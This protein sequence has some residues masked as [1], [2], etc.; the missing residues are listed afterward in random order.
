MF[1][2]LD[3]AA[4][5]PVT[6]VC[7]PP[8]AG[9]TTLVA[10]YLDARKLRTLWYRMDDGDADLASFFYYLSLAAPKQKGSLPLYT[11]EYRQ[12]FR[13]FAGN[14]F[15]SLYSR[16]KSPFV[17]VF[18]DY[19]APAVNSPLNEVMR[20]ALA[21]LP[22]GGK[23]TFISRAEP[24]AFA[25]LKAK[26]MIEVLDWPWLRFTRSEVS[27]LVKRF[28]S[29]KWSNSAIDQL[30]ETSDGWAAG[31]VLL[32]EQLRKNRTTAVKMGH[33]ISQVLFDYFAGE[34]F[35][36]TDPETKRV[37]LQT[38]FLPE[39]TVKIAEELTGNEHAGGLL[40]N[41]HRKNYFTN[42]RVGN[43]R[44]YEYHPL[45]RGFLLEQAK[46]T[47]SPERQKEIR[48][49][50]GDI[51]KTAG[52]I[53]AAA[54]LYR[55]AEEWGELSKLI[56]EHAPVFLRQA[57]MRMV[58]QWVGALPQNVINQNPWLLYWRG[59]CRDIL[60]SGDPLPDFAQGFELFRRQRDAA[61]VFTA[62]SALIIAH[63]RT[64]NV[65]ALDSVVEDLEQLLRNGLKFP[66]ED[67]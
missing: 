27:Q 33:R 65:E 7:G 66:S 58:E 42:R 12:G 41:L 14:F 29:G 48:R 44:A 60:G 30:Y 57:R 1:G 13:I 10:S 5:T 4:N 47:Y 54:E 6:W 34:I 67:V 28:A 11:S 62:G 63:Q 22:A 59:S 55:D 32:V 15:R 43:E 26:Q 24:P 23:V 56:C 37:L 53:E 8:G 9:K 52:R 16:L 61:G 25:E 2:L 3:Q 17:L 45:F 21:E 64:S 49:R 36:R 51:V 39:V 40:G 46:R 31:L 50:A 18:D 19:Q 38:A 20:E 35:K